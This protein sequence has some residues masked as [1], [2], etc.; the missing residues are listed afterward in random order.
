VITHAGL[1]T[2]MAALVYGVPLLCV[3]LKA[4]QFENAAGIVAL[5]AGQRLSRRATSTQLK[6]GAIEV[7]TD[8]RFR[9]A[10]QRLGQALAD[11]QDADPVAELEALARARPAASQPALPAL[12]G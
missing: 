6:R 2:V 5:G 12:A 9:R 7:L 8:S 4:D 3:P 1:E 10:A 11:G